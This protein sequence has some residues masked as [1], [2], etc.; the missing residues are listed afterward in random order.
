SEFALSLVL[1]IAASLLLRSFWDL[2][3]VRLGF[4]PR[5]VMTIRTRLPDPNV[6]SNDKYATASQET[7]LI[8]EL[9]RRCRTLPGVEEVA[10]GD[11]ASIPLDERLRNL[12]VISEG[13]FL[14]SFE[15]WNNQSDHPASVGRSSVSPD[16]FHLLGMPLL[17][18][19]LFNDLDNDNTP[20]VAAV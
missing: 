16:Y 6:P 8:R 19:R 11:T 13:Q 3:N 14:L 9:L 18:G 10:M 4:N 15:R 12:K 2:M 5:S 7:P 17:R 1:M 20:A